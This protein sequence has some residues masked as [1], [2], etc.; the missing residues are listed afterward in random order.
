[1]RTWKEIY[2]L[3]IKLFRKNVRKT[4]FKLWNN[5]QSSVEAQA[6][7]FFQKRLMENDNL[8]KEN[9]GCVEQTPVYSEK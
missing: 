5:I 7:A 3:G 2:N 6:V 1:M 9:G 4:C 8:R